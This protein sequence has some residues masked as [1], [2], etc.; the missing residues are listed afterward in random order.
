MASDSR[1]AFVDPL[2]LDSNRFFEKEKNMSPNILIY[3]YLHIYCICVLYV[4]NEAHVYKS[5][6]AFS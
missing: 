4:R 5:V 1:R 3:I 6:L 2:T